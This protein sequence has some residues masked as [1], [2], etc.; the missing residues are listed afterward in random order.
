MAHMQSQ[1][2]SDEAKSRLAQT[3]GSK[4][5]KLVSQ[6]AS[7]GV[8]PEGLMAVQMVPLVLIAWANHG[9][10][11]KERSIVLSKAKRFGVESRRMPT[12]C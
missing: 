4:D 12:L 9:V 7:L 3:L 1:A 8:T 2:D 10:D 5:R 11:E 6:L